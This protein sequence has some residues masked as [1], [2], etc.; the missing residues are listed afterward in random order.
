MTDSVQV[1]KR[2]ENRVR[3]CYVIILWCT[4]FICIN[5]APPIQGNRL[6][7]MISQKAVRV[8][9]YESFNLEDVHR[10]QLLS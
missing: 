10:L 3:F 2:A 8:D 9:H 7:C 1:K 4:P 5:L 6:R